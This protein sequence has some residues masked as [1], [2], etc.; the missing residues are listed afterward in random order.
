MVLTRTKLL[1][2]RYSV[3]VEPMVIDSSQK[4]VKAFITNCSSEAVMLPPHMTIGL[5]EE[6]SEIEEIELSADDC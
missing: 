5:I 1:Y 3:L 6:A 2:D 4:T